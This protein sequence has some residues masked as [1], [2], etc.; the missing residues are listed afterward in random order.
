MFAIINDA[1]YQG[2][3]TATLVISDGIAN[4]RTNYFQTSENSGQAADGF[5]ADGD[6]LINS[7]EYA[8]GS[9]PTVQSSSQLLTITKNGSGFLLNFNAKQASGT[10]YIGL[11]RTYTVETTNDLT[12]QSSWSPLAGYANIVGAS[13]VITIN[14]SS[15]TTKCFFRLK[16]HVE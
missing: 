16:V 2:T 13:Q 10:G 5:D 12:S 7:L 11:I 3:A 15:V 6:G 8:F 9:D 4:W 14:L 1:I